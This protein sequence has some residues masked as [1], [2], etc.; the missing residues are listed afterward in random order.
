MSAL[1]A[2]VTAVLLAV[3]H[4][5]YCLPIAL[6][7]LLF[8]FIPYVGSFIGEL[9]VGLS[10]LSVRGLKP[11][12]IA[13]AIYL[14]YQQLAGHA[15][16]PLVQRR[17]MRMNPLLM[18]LSLLAGAQLQGVLGAILA[19]PASA[20]AQ[21]LLQELKTERASRWTRPAQEASHCE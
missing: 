1:G 6:A 12:L 4:V 19:L 10:T 13:T 2:V 14:V 17:A 5:P 21:V 11:A 16:S 15:L 20:A 3:F 7:M 8:G 18:L 9:L